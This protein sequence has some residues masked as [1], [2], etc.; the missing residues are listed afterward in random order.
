[1]LHATKFELNSVCT[2]HSHVCVQLTQVEV[3]ELVA[4]P[5]GWLIVVNVENPATEL[6]CKEMDGLQL[7]TLPK[8]KFQTRG[9]GIHLSSCI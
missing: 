6:H 5:P 7:L 4:N 1:M 2:N 8:R 9:Q 3:D